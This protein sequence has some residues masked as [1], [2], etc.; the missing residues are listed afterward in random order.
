ME[1]TLTA[2]TT[3]S[4]DL[5]AIGFSTAEITTLKQL[6]ARFDPFR[7]ACESNREFERLAFL[8]WRIERGEFARA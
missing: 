7:E 8:K 3:T 6:R 5:L 4:R 1:L 2:P